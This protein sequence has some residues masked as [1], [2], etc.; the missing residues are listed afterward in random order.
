MRLI[1]R[2][3]GTVMIFTVLVLLML[4]G[5]VG[6]AVDWGYTYRTAQQLQIAADA[7]ALAG[8]ENLFLS[9]VSARS[10]AISLAAANNAAGKVVSLQDNPSNVSTGDIV[11][12]TYDRPT[13]TFTPTSQ[14]SAN[15]VYIVARRTT[16][17]IGGALPLLF[18]PIFGKSSAEVSRG[19]IAL[20]EGTPSYANVI[21]LD[22]HSPDSLYLHGNPTLDLGTGS[23]QV[24]SDNS[25]AMD[26]KGTPVSLIAGEADIVGNYTKSGNPTL[27]VMNTSE[28][29]VADPLSSLP[30]PTVGAA[31]S[32]AQIS[33][34]RTF[35]PGYYPQGLA[36]NAGDN[37]T[38]TP[39]VYVLDAGFSINGH[40]TLNAQGVIFYIKSGTVSDN[41]TAEIDISPPTSGTYQGISFFQSRTDAS[42]AS[43]TGTALL[44]G[45][46]SSDTKG[47]G[48]F[49]FPDALLQ[50][51]GTADVYV[52]K[53]I[54]KT[55]EVFGSGT[56]HVTD[57]Y[58]GN[59]AGNK[60]FLVQ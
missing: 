56:K 18:G 38:L 8:A 46:G 22:P 45:T 30:A 40:A 53:L 51:G 26:I 20:S 25:K 11:L 14:P 37:V 27:P 55:I 54:A 23:V 48:T 12:G 24:D 19:A 60:S 42:T 43:F 32:P 1:D 2:H 9:H 41:G 49:Y 59:Q 50:V 36:M 16:G 34:T 13:R 10:A 52:S 47:A 4:I 5:F 31:M 17:S 28:P 21:A 58:G 39:G 44:T 15:A 35:N 3:R 57:G 7:A 29:F 6:L 33:G